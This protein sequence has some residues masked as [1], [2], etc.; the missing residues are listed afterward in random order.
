MDHVLAGLGLRLTYLHDPYALDDLDRDR[1]LDDLSDDTAGGDAFPWLTR[2]PLVDYHHLVLVTA[3]STGR[4][5]AFLAANDGA[6]PKEDFLLLKTAFVASAAR[7]QNL[8]RRMIALALLRISTIRGV[9]SAIVACTR[10]PLCYR[11]MRDTARRLTSAVFFPDPDSVAINFRAATLAQRIAKEI[12]P[13][14]RFQAVSGT[15]RGAMI[16]ATGT[17][18]RHAMSYD[19]QI[20]DFF[21]RR[22][23][24][25]DRMLAV[26]DLRN[27]DE[28]IILDDAQHIYRAK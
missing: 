23:Q 16:A 6:T 17:E 19:A 3:R 2:S 12:E 28:A 5:L 4:Y 25:A 15:I 10:S 1:I 14:R 21:G 20:D 18:H 7:G 8:M 24:P 9:P 11:I 13:N 26:L 22:M 27:T